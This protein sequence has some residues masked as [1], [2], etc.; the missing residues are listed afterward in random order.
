VRPVTGFKT[1]LWAILSAPLIWLIYL[2]ILE[3]DMP[4]TV[5]GADPGEAVVHYLGIWSLRGLLLAFTVTPV[6]RLTGYSY[7]ARCR[8]LLGLWAFAY[9]VCHL[10]A[11]L[12]FFIQFD[13]QLLLND[14]IERAYITAG[15]VAWFCLFCMAITSTR[16][17]Q[18]RL[19]Q[20][21]RQLHSVIYLAVAAALVHFWWF[22]RDQYGEVLLYCAWFLGV[23]CFR[24]F[25]R[26]A[27]TAS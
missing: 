9:V 2:I 11:Y 26:R 20:R 1:L 23:L 25:F 13:W 18:R 19:R 3:L 17:W 8:R 15:M 16:G 6:Y 22:T 14:F 7:I 24:Y 21:W 27:R 4:A 5:L 12:F 10:T